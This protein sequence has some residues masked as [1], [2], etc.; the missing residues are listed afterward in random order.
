MTWFK[1]R[2]KTTLQ[3]SD[4][5]STPTEM[6][7]LVDRVTHNIAK[8]EDAE[9]GRPRF[10]RDHGFE[11]GEMVECAVCGKSL[12]V[13]IMKYAQMTVATMDVWTGIALICGDC[14]RLFCVDCALRRHPNLPSCDQCQ[15]IGG[16]TALMN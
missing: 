13:R 16:V 14:G 11:N 9:P 2:K 15:E 10:D 1:R 5:G 4:P 6:Q 7:A 12:E 8:D 3:R